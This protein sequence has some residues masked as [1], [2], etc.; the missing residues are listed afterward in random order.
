MKVDWIAGEST[1]PIYS[2]NCKTPK[3][4]PSLRSL[5][6]NRRHILP[7]FK[8]NRYFPTTMSFRPGYLWNI[9][10]KR[11]IPRLKPP[12][13]SESVS[14]GLKPCLSGE[15]MRLSWGKKKGK[16]LECNGCSRHCHFYILPFSPVGHRRT[17]QD[18]KYDNCV[19][20][21]TCGKVNHWC[22]VDEESKIESYIVTMAF[23][24]LDIFC[25]DIIAFEPESSHM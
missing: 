4:L 11:P 1:S 25:R 19:L 15:K 13:A 22:Y 24:L 7:I 6:P 20:L 18:I 5:V 2:I 8:E 3:L 10:A 23:H 9:G 12:C 16:Q 14:K 17:R 21:T